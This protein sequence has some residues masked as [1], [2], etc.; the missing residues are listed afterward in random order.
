L[1][2]NT[3]PTA[4]TE[5]LELARQRV[6]IRSRSGNVRFLSAFS[7]RRAPRKEEHQEVICVCRT[8]AKPLV[9]PKKRGKEIQGDDNTWQAT[10]E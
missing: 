10:V 4:F 9:K 7:G 6:Y 8:G 1:A 3:T 2:L 5:S